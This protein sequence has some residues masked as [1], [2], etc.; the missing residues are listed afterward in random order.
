MRGQMKKHLIIAII[1]LSIYIIIINTFNILASYSWQGQNGIIQKQIIIGATAEE[2]KL[3]D[4]LSL[5]VLRKRWYGRIYETIESQGK[6]SNLY[7]L[8][9][10]K[11]PLTNYDISYVAF[12]II[13]LISILI[14]ISIAA[15]IRLINYRKYKYYGYI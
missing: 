11:L 10:I 8:G 9:F 14:Y 7:L 13:F 5:S 3:S 15:T 2:A 1:L 6:L 4:S 12:H